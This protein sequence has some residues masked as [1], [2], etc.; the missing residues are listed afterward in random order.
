M[1]KTFRYLGCFIGGALLLTLI[2]GCVSKSTAKEQARQAYLAGR[3]D[4]LAQMDARANSVTFIGP[5]KNPTVPWTEG[6]TLAKAILAAVYD[7]QTDPAMI[8]IHRRSEEIQ[9]DPSRLLGGDDFPIKGGDV[10]EFQMPPD[11]APS[12]RK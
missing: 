7:S 3:R 11:S 6:L 8:V 1:K 12:L 4:A 2:A 5:V 9:V 10:V